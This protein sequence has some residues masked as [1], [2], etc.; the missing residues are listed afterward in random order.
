MLRFRFHSTSSIPAA[1]SLTLPAV[2]YPRRSFSN[3]EFQETDCLA[4]EGEYVA[5]A[6]DDG[7]VRLFNFPCVIEHAPHRCGG[8]GWPWGGVGGDCCGWGCN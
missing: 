2:P 5:A 3:P 1:L 7:R 8:S 6:Y 4:G